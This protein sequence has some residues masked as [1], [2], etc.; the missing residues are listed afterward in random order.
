VD[1]GTSRSDGENGNASLD[2]SEEWRLLQVVNPPLQACEWIRRVRTWRR[3]SSPR[4][5]A[6]TAFEKPRFPFLQHEL[7]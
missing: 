7:S 5:V 4:V 2:H 6:I 1:R 3:F